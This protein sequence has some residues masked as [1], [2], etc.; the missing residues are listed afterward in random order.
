MPTLLVAAGTLIQ[1]CF[2]GGDPET[3]PLTNLPAVDQT[4]VEPDRVSFLSLSGGLETTFIYD[5]V[6]QNLKYDGTRLTK[7][8]FVAAPNPDTESAHTPGSIP[9]GKRQIKITLSTEQH[10]GPPSPAFLEVEVTVTT[11]QQYTIPSPVRGTGPN[12]F[13]DPQVTTWSVYSTIQ[14]GGTYR[15]VDSADIDVDIVVNLTDTALEERDPLQQFVNEAPPAPAVALCEHRG[16]VVGVFT[17]DLN[18]LRFSY[19][20][21]SYMVPEGWPEDYVQPVA[22]SDGDHITSLA[23]MHEWLVAFKENATF[24][25]AGESF[26]EYKVVPILAAGGGKHI[27]IGCFA[28]G[29]VLQVE[30][31]IMFASR[32]GIYRISRFASAAGGIEAER[33]SGAIDDL[34]A[35]AKFSLGA[36]CFFDRNRRVFVFLGH[37]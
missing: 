13:D 5:G 23:S 2:E 21:E 14:G 26:E 15:F 31:A 11:G 35:A 37:G 9:K 4:R 6:N 30:N 28:P 29:T 34:Y 33:L 16:Q 20:D 22:H 25:V 19:M 3:L 12:E 32:D 18:L 7:M 27:G 24:A 17:D 1:S 36:T 10:E 8:G